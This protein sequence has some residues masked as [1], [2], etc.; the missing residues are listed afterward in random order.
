M[1]TDSVFAGAISFAGGLGRSLVFVSSWIGLNP[2]VRD[3]AGIPKSGVPVELGMAPTGMFGDSGAGMEWTLGLGFSGVCFTGVIS[4]TGLLVAIGEGAPAAFGVLVTSI[5]WPSSGFS[6]MET[7]PAPG[8]WFLVTGAGLA[9][10][11]FR[12]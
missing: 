10:S 4:E 7:A 1:I 8:I 3:V 5:G 9:S 2:G 6:G 11:L 12:E